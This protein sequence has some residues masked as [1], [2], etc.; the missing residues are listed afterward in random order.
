MKPD[1]T[2]LVHQKEKREPVNWNPPGCKARVRL[3]REGLEI[4]SRRA[5]PRESLRVLFKD[6]KLAASFE[7]VD[8]AELNLVGSEE[9]LVDAAYNDPEMIE[10]GFKPIEKQMSTRYGLADLYGVDR[11]G[12]G[13]VVEFKRG[14]ATL[15]GV[16]QLK[17]YVEELRKKFRKRVRGVLAAPRISPSALRL[18]DKEGLEYVRIGRPPSAW[19]EESI[20]DARQKRIREFARSSGE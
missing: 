17:R 19:A 9:E 14:Q 15:A 6:L 10:E 11:D 12:N 13:V 5:K 18:L 16:S 7:L 8:E 20:R 1:G 4:H 3:G 2:L